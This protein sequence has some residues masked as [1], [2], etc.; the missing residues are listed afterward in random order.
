MRTRGVSRASVGF[1]CQQGA[2]LLIVT[3]TRDQAVA[4]AVCLSFAESVGD[5]A[6]A[7]TAC[8]AHAKTQAG[9]LRLEEPK[10]ADAPCFSAFGAWSAKPGR[11]PDR[12]IRAGI[13]TIHVMPGYVR[14]ATASVNSPAAGRQRNGHDTRAID[15]GRPSRRGAVKHGLIGQF[16]FQSGAKPPALRSW[17]IPPEF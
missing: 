12:E 2:K 14:W 15:H 7:T 10:L 5:P 17:L 3:F 11:I 13:V 9:M 4:L 1:L 16:R 6:L 8:E